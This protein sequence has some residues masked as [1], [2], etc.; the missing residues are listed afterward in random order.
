MVTC[1]A[2]PRCLPSMIT[3]LLFAPCGLV[4]HLPW[5]ARCMVSSG[6]GRWSPCSMRRR[7][8]NSWRSG[9]VPA[10]SKASMRPSLTWARGATFNAPRKPPVVTHICGLRHEPMTTLDTANTGAASSSCTINTSHG[11]KRHGSPTFSAPVATVSPSARK[12]SP[13]SNHTCVAPC[14]TADAVAASSLAN[15]QSWGVTPTAPHAAP[16]S[17][18]T[19]LH[20]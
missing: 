4:G 15:A 5:A 20:L 19:L 10:N 8:S 9:M 18:V 17:I 6:C 16:F 3:A 12:I 13:Y 11:N 2:R 7:M 1:A 14:C